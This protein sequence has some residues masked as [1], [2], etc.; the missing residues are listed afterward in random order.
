MLPTWNSTLANACI[1]DFQAGELCLHLLDDQL[2]VPARVQGIVA[3]HTF[4][5]GLDAAPW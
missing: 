1:V 2:S 4:K 3:L 5:D